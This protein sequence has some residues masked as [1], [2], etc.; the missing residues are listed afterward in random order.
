MIS[1]EIWCKIRH[2]LDVEQLSLRQTAQA[3]G[4]HVRTVSSW[5]RLAHYEARL[6]VPRASV[7]DPY[8]GEITRMLDTHPYSAQQILQ[9]LR[10]M[11]YP[12]GYSIVKDYVRR[13]RRKPQSAFLKLVF[14]PGE[15]AQVDWGEY[16][17]GRQ[18]SSQALF[19]RHG[20]VP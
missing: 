5:A 6:A 10:E 16:G 17:T 2:A 3:L 14:A 1:Y 7:L 13:V 19:L 15:A 12:G 11:G 20:A 4:L 18:Y 9:R 8:K